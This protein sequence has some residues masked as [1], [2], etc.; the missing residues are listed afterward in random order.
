MADNRANN[1]YSP[2]CQPTAKHKLR[3]HRSISNIILLTAKTQHHRQIRSLRRSLIY[4]SI[5]SST[6]AAA[7][8]AVGVGGCK[9]LA[10]ERLREMNSSSHSIH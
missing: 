8:A 2:V 5:C 9:R 10:K 3:L 1:S 7:A 6:A 4:W